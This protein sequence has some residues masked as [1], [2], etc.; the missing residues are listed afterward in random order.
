MNEVEIFCRGGC[1]ELEW[2]IRVTPVYRIG[3]GKNMF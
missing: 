3:K 2:G 1:L